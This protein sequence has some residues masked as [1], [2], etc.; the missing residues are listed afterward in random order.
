MRHDQK[1]INALPFSLL[2]IQISKL[3]ETQAWGVMFALDPAILSLIEFIE[4][5]NN[6][7]DI[8]YA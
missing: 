4:K 3:L 2:V 5:N 8:K 1:L 7:Y 6:V